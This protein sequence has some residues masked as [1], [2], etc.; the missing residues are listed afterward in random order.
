MN[1]SLFET[2]H[3][4]LVCV[5]ATALTTPSVAQDVPLADIS[6]AKHH[7]VRVKSPGRYSEPEL[8]AIAFSPDGTILAVAA[9]SERIQFVETK[10]GDVI[11]GIPDYVGTVISMSFSRDG[12]RFFVIG[13]NR[14]KLFDVA[15]GKEIPVAPNRDQ[16]EL[17]IDLEYR[18]GKWLV[19]DLKSQGAVARNGRIRIGDE[20]TGIGH[21][22]WGEIQTIVGKE[23]SEI[24]RLLR[25][26]A[27]TFV[28]LEYIA[29]GTTK[30]QKVIIQRDDPRRLVSVSQ[31]DVDRRFAENKAW[32]IQGHYH[33]FFNAATGKRVRSLRLEQIGNNVGN[34]AISPNAERFAFLGKTLGKDPE[35]AIE[36][37]DIRTRKRIS[38]VN[39]FKTHVPTGSAWR[40]TT[41]H[42][43]KFTPD[44]N[45]LLVACW[46][47]VCEFSVEESKLRKVFNV[48]PALQVANDRIRVA[49]YRSGDSLMEQAS[50]SDSGVIDPR[51]PH[52]Q[53]QIETFDLSSSGLLA[54]GRWGEVKVFDY[55]TGELV[56]SFRG[57]PKNKSVEHIQFAPNG[58]LL[59]FYVHGELHLCEM[60]S[61]KK[62]SLSQI[63]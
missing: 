41:F 31:A 51:E 46:D 27:E 22:K 20:L 1:R 52:M 23:G 36:V 53:R 18:N 26:P 50:L 33:A 12:K 61:I 40:S 62:N 45:N 49:G 5:F 43:V 34:Q 14:Q 38:F 54:I 55:E 25:G 44:N 2:S 35:Y 10:T 9:D 59:A 7:V 4:F 63:K 21:G 3:A 32:C 60:G 13:T 6:V 15:S 28:Q 47:R 17:G 8:K 24:P 56:C 37:F 11:G 42:D 57:L 39:Q 58:R 29:A 19:L 16:G 48:N 30:R